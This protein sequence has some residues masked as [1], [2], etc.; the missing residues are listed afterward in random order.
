MPV[1]TIRGGLGSGAPEVGKLVAERLNIGY[2]DRE[3]IADVAA[4][5]QRYEED[6]LL[7]EMPPGTVL[8]RIADALAHVQTLGT[9]FE[10]VYLPT[11][12][13]PL[14]DDVHYLEALQSVIKDLAASGSIVICG[15]GGEF[16][17]KNR[18]DAFHVRV[19][20][21]LPVRVKR[22]MEELKLGEQA[23]KQEMGRWDRSHREF[24]RRH[25]HAE[26][27]DAS[28]FDLVLNTAHLDFAA[29]ADVIVH[30]LP[31]KK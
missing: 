25:F 10:G 29:A 11:W 4:R 17:L 23:A 12:Q 26:L 1:V 6:I 19:V 2:A 20:A 8:G 15:R 16:I 27:E 7:K 21:P 30:A 5:L 24:I 31:L 13:T 28:Y 22:I 3:I 9:A 18:S 14:P